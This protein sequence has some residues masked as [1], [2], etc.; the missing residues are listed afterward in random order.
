MDILKQALFPI[1]EH[2]PDR[3]ALI[4]AENPLDHT[5]PERCVITFF[6][7]ELR[8]KAER[9]RLPVLTAMGS[10]IL[11]IPVYECVVDGERVCL[12]MAFLSAPG[13]AVTLENLQVMGCKKFIVCGGA[14]CLIPGSQLGGLVLPTA[15]VR[16]EGTS[17]HYLPPAREVACGEA[18]LEH[19]RRALS[20]LGVPFIEGK[21]WTTD[22]MMRETR[23]KIALRRDEGCVT[24][25]MEAAAFFAVAQFYG[26]S[27][28]QVL[29]AGDDV[30]GDTW[31]SRGWNRQK[32]VREN[33]ME[34]SLKLVLAL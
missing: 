29:Y 32:S 11:D 21:T 5:L 22:G 30:S 20:E 28:A 25:E 23:K 7:D 1:L 19:V 8:A 12:T 27:L 10:E 33:L 34:L 4:C 3:D 15:A 24:V 9:E 31:D 13:A 2:D 26:L 18:A 6:G 16:D 17:Y 14:G